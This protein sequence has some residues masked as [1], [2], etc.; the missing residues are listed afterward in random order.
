VIAVTDHPVRDHLGAR[1]EAAEKLLGILL[2]DRRLANLLI[3]QHLAVGVDGLALPLRHQPLDEVVGGLVVR[4][5]ELGGVRRIE[6]RQVDLDPRQEVGDLLVQRPVLLAVVK[7][8]T[9]N[10]DAGL[11]EGLVK[12]SRRLGELR[13]LHHRRSEVPEAPG[14][15]HAGSA[16]GEQRD[17]LLEASQPV[18]VRPHMVDTFVNPLAEVLSCEGSG[19]EIIC[20][21]VGFEQSIDIIIRQRHRV[22]L[23]DRPRHM[24]GEP[25]TVV[26]DYPQSLLLEHVR[27]NRTAA[28]SVQD[29][30]HPV[31]RVLPDPVDE[32][33]LRA[34]VAGDVVRGCVLLF[35]CRHS[36][37]GIAFEQELQ[38]RVFGFEHRMAF[39]KPCHGVLPGAYPLLPVTYPKPSRND[40]TIGAGRISS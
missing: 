26:G 13:T 33:P 31:G 40:E 3:L 27:H 12:L 10:G 16:Q 20:F 4:G 28:E 22:I 2:G 9:I 37:Q 29:R 35:G 14:G 11:A 36:Q 7:D 15:V 23:D 39:L 6:V 34:D 8:Q 5:R 17:V 21:G 19:Y 24:P 30:T 25:E 18:N 1:Q 32:F 38:G